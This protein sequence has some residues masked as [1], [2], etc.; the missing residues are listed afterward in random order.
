M[1]I[2]ELRHSYESIETADLNLPE[3]WR[4]PSAAPRNA[5]IIKRFIDLT[6]A[7]LG[8]TLL[9]PIFLLVALLIR[10]T[11]PGPA[12]FRQLRLGH[13]GLPFQIVK[14]R[15]MIAGAEHCLAEREVRDKADREGLL[16]IRH[17]PRITPLGWL[18]RRTSLDELPQ[19]WNILRG[20]MSLVGPRP[21]NYRDCTRLKHLDPIRFERRLAV[22]PGMSGLA[23]VSGR[24]DLSHGAI[25]EFDIDYIE[26]WSLILDLR[27]LLRTLPAVAL[28]RG[29]Y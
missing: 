15:T 2:L 14:F 11:S 5:A 6:V 24:G 10:T 26:N 29:A 22:R 1:E 21:Y 12:L 8:L 16:K 19:L 13:S 9:S 7:I 23:Q 18:L 4:I 25:L 17:D 27:I 3:F 20:E 28:G